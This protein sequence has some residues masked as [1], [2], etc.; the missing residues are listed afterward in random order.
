MQISATGDADVTVLVD[1]V[2]T[3]D[4]DDLVTVS[5]GGRSGS[6]TTNGFVGATRFIKVV[7][8]DGADA[9]TGKYTLGFRRIGVAIQ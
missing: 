1:T 5:L 6:A 7:A 4:S 9:D 3:F 2:A 8:A